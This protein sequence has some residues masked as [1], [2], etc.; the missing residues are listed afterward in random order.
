VNRRLDRRDI[1]S[2]IARL[3][4]GDSLEHQLSCPQNNPIRDH[5]GEEVGHVGLEVRR[6]GVVERRVA[7]HRDAAADDIRRLTL[8][9]QR[10]DE[11]SPLGFQSVVSTIRKTG[12][13]IGSTTAR[14]GI[15]KASVAFSIVEEVN[16]LGRV[17]RTIVLSELAAAADPVGPSLRAAP[18]SGREPARQW[19]SR[20]H[21]RPLCPK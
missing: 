12:D 20:H 15:T 2:G 16:R 4:Q 13:V 7:A 11:S 1:G 3:P 10:S 21:R 19:R 8:S 18:P 17:V 6:L 5:K 14:A 9:S